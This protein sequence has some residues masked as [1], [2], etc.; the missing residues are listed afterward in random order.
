VR[1]IETWAEWTTWVPVF[2]W[3]LITA[4]WTLSVVFHRK[5]SNTRVPMQLAA[6]LWSVTL[7]LIQRMNAWAKTW[8]FLLPLVLMWAAAGSVGL[9]GKIRLKFLRG[10]PLAVVFIGLA[11]PAGFPFA[12]WLIPQ[13][14]AIWAD[15]GPEEKA[16]MFVQSQLR[17]GDLIVV[18]SPD[19]AAVWYYSKLHHIPDTRFDLRKDASGR[20]LVLVDPGEGQ[21]PGSVIAARGP[22]PSLLDARSCVLMQSFGKMQVFDCPRKISLNTH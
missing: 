1:F 18:D 7:I 8:L 13:L 21:T 15:Q 10:L 20:Y 12:A 17:G 14:P 4:G 5:L 3:V 22:D 6:I 19:D 11:L 2:V 16:V 9:L